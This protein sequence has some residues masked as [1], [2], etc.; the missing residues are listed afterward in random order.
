MSDDN[1]KQQANSALSQVLCR[2]RAEK[3]LSQGHTH[4]ASLHHRGTCS[5]K[6]TRRG[7]QTAGLEFRWP[8]CYSQQGMATDSLACI[9]A[10]VLV[11]LLKDKRQHVST[12]LSTTE[13]ALKWPY[14]P[15]RSSIISSL[16]TCN[17]ASPQHSLSQS[18]RLIPRLVLVQ[19][20]QQ[21]RPGCEVTDTPA[22]SH[23][24]SLCRKA[25]SGLLTC[26]HPEFCTA[27]WDFLLPLVTASPFKMHVV[28]NDPS[29]PPQ[30]RK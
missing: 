20:L 27:C 10:K 14:V 2:A 4:Q 1:R 12:A 18:S 15:V 17:N 23:L 7:F 13:P 16:G 28:T 3:G 8:C 26:S 30:R 19:H 25:G 22:W 5:T 9:R 21:E 11:D 29:L 6:G 24:S